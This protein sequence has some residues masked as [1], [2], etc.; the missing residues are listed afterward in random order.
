MLNCWTEHRDET[1]FLLALRAQ[2]ADVRV[3]MTG[4]RNWVVLAG[5][6]SD[7][8]SASALKDKAQRLAAE[9]GFPLQ[10]YLSR[11]CQLD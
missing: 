3:V 10:R 11:N 2:F 9:M 6:V 7:L 4:S 1:D 8:Q 5:K